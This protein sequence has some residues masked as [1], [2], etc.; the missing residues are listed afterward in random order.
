MPAKLPSLLQAAVFTG[1][2]LWAAV[3]DAR[4]KTVPAE[5]IIIIAL[6]GLIDFSPVKY[7]GLVLALPFYIAAGLGRAG[8]GD[9]WIVAACGLVLGLRRGTAGLMFGL[10]MF[11]IY[12]LIVKPYRISSPESA[13]SACICS[14]KPKPT[15][16]ARTRRRTRLTR[17]QNNRFDTMHRPPSGSN[18]AEG[19]FFMPTP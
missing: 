16:A 13:P 17:K 3:E 10:A 9:V 8:A 7:R 6:T 19:N 4:T 1:A 15:R 14:P 18:R 12:Y 11:I 2:L 5:S